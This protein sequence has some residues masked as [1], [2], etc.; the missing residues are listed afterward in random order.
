MSPIKVYLDNQPISD[1]DAEIKRIAHKPRMYHLIDEVLYRQ[2][3][4]GMIMKCICKDE[5][6]QLLR[7]I[8]SGVYGAHSS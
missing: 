7:D 5:G 6:S 8:H 3:G 1:D 2:S 4:N